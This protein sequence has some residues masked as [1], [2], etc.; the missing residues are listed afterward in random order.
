VVVA[1][2]LVVVMAVV[3]FERSGMIKVN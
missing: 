2:T 3:A 1:V